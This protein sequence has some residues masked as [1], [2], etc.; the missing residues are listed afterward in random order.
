MHSSVIAVA[1]G[2]DL[3]QQHLSIGIRSSEVKLHGVAD[4]L[5]NAIEEKVPGVFELRTVILGHTQR[6]GAPI[7]ADRLLAKRFGVAAIE[8]FDAGKFGMMVRLKDDVVGLTTLKRARGLKLV[9][10]DDPCYQTARKL[11]VYLS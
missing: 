11:G 2:L 6:G 9:T 3:G 4:A 10:R 5:M 1:E 7:P 8:A